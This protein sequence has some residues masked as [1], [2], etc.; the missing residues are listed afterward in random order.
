M[1]QHELAGRGYGPD[2]DVTNKYTVNLA[3]PDRVALATDLDNWFTN[4]Y[5]NYNDPNKYNLPAFPQ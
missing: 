1:V 2:V 4:H 3:N 5:P